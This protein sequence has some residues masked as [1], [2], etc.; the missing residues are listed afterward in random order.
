MLQWL[1]AY[2]CFHSNQSSI[3]ETTQNDFST[4][5]LNEFF[6]GTT[7][8]EIIFEWSEYKTKKGQNAIFGPITL[9]IKQQTIA[10][11]LETHFNCAIEG[12]KSPDVSL[13][14]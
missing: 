11:A 3:D 7:K 12:Y 2:M 8:D 10:K 5:E 4:E 9:D 1:V 6:F 14:Y 13:I